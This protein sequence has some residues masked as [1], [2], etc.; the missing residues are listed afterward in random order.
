MD[1]PRL[2][3]RGWVWPVFLAIKAETV[4]V[5]RFDSLYNGEMVTHILGRERHSPFLWRDKVNFDLLDHGSPNAEGAAAISQVR[6]PQ[7]DLLISA[8]FF[9]LH[10]PFA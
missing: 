2:K 8:F 1:T 10:D 3:P 7:M 9:A 5:P 6:G 4:Q